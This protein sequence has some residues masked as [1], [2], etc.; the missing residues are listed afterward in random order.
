VVGA[1]VLLLVYHLV[2]SRSGRSSRR[3]FFA[4]R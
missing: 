4:H 1:A 3:G 2:T